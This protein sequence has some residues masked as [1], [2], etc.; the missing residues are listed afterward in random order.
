MN[1]RVFL[2]LGMKS[3]VLL[4]LSEVALARIVSTYQ[5]TVSSVLMS[6]DEKKLVV[7]VASASSMGLFA[8]VGEF[9]M[10]SVPGPVRA[11]RTDRRSDRSRP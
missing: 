4:T 5:E 2:A 10:K 6:A 3:A 7:R 8:P 11:S 9:D 1:R